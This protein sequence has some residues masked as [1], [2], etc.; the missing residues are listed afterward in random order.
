MV[1]L[2][3]LIVQFP[4]SKTLWTLVSTIHYTRDLGMQ[5]AIT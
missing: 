2:H 4:P 3:A 1:P 5:L